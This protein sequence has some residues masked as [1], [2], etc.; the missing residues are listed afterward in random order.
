MY[1]LIPLFL[2]LYLMNVR[3]KVRIEKL[4]MAHTN[5]ENITVYI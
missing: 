1:C 4:Y 3:A 2:R 5:A